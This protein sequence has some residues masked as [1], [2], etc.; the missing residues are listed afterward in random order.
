MRGSGPI[1]GTTET[2]N[3]LDNAL[4]RGYRGLAGQSS[5]RQLLEEHRPVWFPQRRFEPLTAKQILS[6][7][8]QFYAQHGKRPS[9]SSGEVT[10]TSETWEFIDNALR[11][12]LR[13]LPSGSSLSQFLNKHRPQW[14]SSGAWRNKRANPLSLKQILRWADQYHARH[15]RRPVHIS[16]AISGTTYS[17]HAIEGALRDGRHGLPGGSSLARLLSKCRPQWP[18]NRFLPRLNKRTLT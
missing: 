18:D 11:T 10:G 5:L 3:R 12:G 6:W 17:W 7:A 4:K 8:D 14:P 16:G 9:L 2:W 1:A 15:G 13:G